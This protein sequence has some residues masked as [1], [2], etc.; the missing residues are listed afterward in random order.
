MISRRTLVKLL[1]STVITPWSLHAKQTTPNLTVGCASG[2][3][4]HDSVIIWAKADSA[5]QILVEVD[6]NSDFTSA[7]RFYGSFGTVEND[8]NMHCEL[9]DLQAGQHYYYRVYAQLAGDPKQVSDALEGR[10]VTAPTQS[11]H[12][13]FCWSGDV[14]GQGYGI[15]KSR[16]GMMIFNTMLNHKPDF[17][18]HSGDQIYADNPLESLKQLDDGTVWHS[19]VTKGK[20]KVAETAQ[21]FRENFYYNYLDEHYRRFFASVPVY[22]QWDDHEVR[23]NWYPGE[24][25]TDERYREKRVSVLAK[26]SKQ[27]LFDCNPLRYQTEQR[28]YRQ[29][30]YGPQ[31]ALFFLDLRSFRGANS[32]NQQ[33]E[34]SAETAFMGD[35]QLAWLKQALAESKATWKIICSDMPIGLMV[36][37]WGT[38][39]AENASNIDGEPLGREL[40]LAELFRFIHHQNIKNTHFITADV[41]YCASHYYNPE[42]AQFKDFSPFW[43]FVSGPL[44]AGTF[45]PGKFDNTFGPEA[46][47]IGIP[48]DMKPNRPP[49]EGFQFFGQIEIDKNTQAMTVSH[50]DMA[51]N[52]LW[53]KTLDPET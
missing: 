10:F 23:N 38:D 18:V 27:A 35:E 43:E 21:E 36:K 17:F 12:I 48:Q 53:S 14:V 30:A 2:D 39:I 41:H 42:K 34:R 8:F 29:Y 24:V 4:T 15:D 28:V 37:G 51:D 44:H 52:L 1:A 6:T 22:Q 47:F 3:V 50:F 46:K 40:E 45:G 16:G 7:Q 25:L 33:T 20:A 32:L 26:N 5:A 13:R 9:K 11:K 19:I 31:L 49:S